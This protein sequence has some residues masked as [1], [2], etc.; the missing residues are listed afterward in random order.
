M[1]SQIHQRQS[2]PIAPSHREVRIL[3]SFLIAPSRPYAALPS[4]LI[5]VVVPF[6]VLYSN[7]T[8]YIPAFTDDN[9]HDTIDEWAAES[10]RAATVATH[11]AISTW[12]VSR[13][14]DMSYLFKGQHS[15]NEDLSAWDVAQVALYDSAALSLRCRCPLTANLLLLSLPACRHLY[16][17][18]RILLAHVGD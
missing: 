11:G 9:L 6:T 2:S 12:D 14:T 7:P 17:H 15:F 4:H 18:A 1:Q 5:F 16:T 8:L 10:T 3:S 13:V